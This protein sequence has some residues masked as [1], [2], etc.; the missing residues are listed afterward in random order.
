METL[1]DYCRG[2]GETL[3]PQAAAFEA[4]RRV[5]A[6]VMREL[7]ER[8]FF[9]RFVPRAYGGDE[10]DPTIVLEELEALA[11]GDSSVGWCAMISAT[12][13][14][15]SAYMSPEA[16]RTIFAADPTTIAGGVFAPRGRAVVSEEGYRLS[17]RWDFASNCE[18]ARWLGLGAL[19]FEG[20]AP[21]RTADGRPEVR[22]LM[23]PTSAVTIVPHW[24]VL[25]L[26]GT[27]SHAIEVADVQVPAGF[28]FAIS[29]PQVDAPLYRLPFFGLLS[30]CIAAVAVGI[31]GAALAAM[32]RG[33]E[34]VPFGATKPLASRPSLQASL[35]AATAK[36]ESARAFLFEVTREATIAAAA[37]AAP[38][39][40]ARARA[41]IAAC[42][43]VGR[44]AEVVDLAFN[45]LGGG[46]IRD[47]DEIQ[48]RFRD[49][50]TLTQHVMVGPVALDMAGRVLAGVEVDTSTL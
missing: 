42:E 39:L 25:G 2:L 11:R 31:A 21:R 26:R 17:G 20:K 30:L 32:Q 43:V 9:R 14:A 27:G 3:G 28:S 12:T 38:G 44:A 5:P 49:V 10:A 22:F 46:S 48:R 29:E 18:N 23:V 37:G 4:A 19:V 34:R 15:F 36:Y 35:A 33:A 1:L 40:R 8:G 50:H 13:A 24:D 7:A 45:S 41:R 6:E 47:G 16:A